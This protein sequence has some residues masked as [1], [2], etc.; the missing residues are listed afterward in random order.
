MI[1]TF[2][3]KGLQRFYESGETKYLP[4]HQI[5]RIRR[6]LTFLD[7]ATKP[8]DMNIPGFHFHALKGDHKDFYAVSVAANWRIIFRFSGKNVCDVDYVDYH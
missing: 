7:A 4:A 2:H 6:V 1:E 5:V 3:H 8:E